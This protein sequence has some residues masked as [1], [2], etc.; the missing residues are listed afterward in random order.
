VIGAEDDNR[1]NASLG[2][3]FYVIDSLEAAEEATLR[4]RQGEHA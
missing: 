3:Q 4:T 2:K 1:T